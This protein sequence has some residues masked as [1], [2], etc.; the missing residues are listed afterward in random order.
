MATLQ[1][2]ESVAR[3]ERRF[4][5]WDYVLVGIFV[6]LFCQLQYYIAV[7]MIGGEE[8]QILQT[9]I[10]ENSLNFFF[11]TIWKGFLVVLVLVWLYDY[12]YH[13]A[14]EDTA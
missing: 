9:S 12:F 14:E 3:P 10:E 2:A 6:V 4:Y 13:D 1:A 7:W 8:G 5:W 11:G